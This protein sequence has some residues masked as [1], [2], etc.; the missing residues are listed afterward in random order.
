MGILSLI[1]I[2]HGLHK[3]SP[4][5]CTGGGGGDMST[6]TDGR[7]PVVCSPPF[8]VSLELLVSHSALL[9]LQL[10]LR[11]GVS[12]VAMP[13]VGVWTLQTVPTPTPR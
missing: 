4:T 2:L 3:T 9:L 6:V 13:S 10:L 7:C 5:A 8:L 12:V 11:Q 1:A